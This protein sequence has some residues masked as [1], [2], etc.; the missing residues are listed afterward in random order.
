MLFVAMV[1]TEGVAW[2]FAEH[3]RTT[4]PAID[5]RTV[6]SSREAYDAVERWSLLDL[7]LR[8]R[9]NG[10]LL[11]ALRAVGDRVIANYRREAPAV[12]PEEWRQ[13][14]AAFSWARTLAPRDSSLR[15]KELIAD[16]HVRRLTA[17]KARPA[18][19]ATAIAQTALARFRAAALADPTSPDPYIGMAVTQV[20]SLGDIDGALGSLDEAANRGYTATRRE[21]ALL[22]DA[23]MRRGISGRR[24]AVVLTGEQ[25]RDALDKARSD[26]ER[27]VSSFEP[28]VEFGKAAEHL[29]ACKA[30]VRRVDQQLETDEF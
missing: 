19:N 4:M 8:L 18:S 28:I 10:P 15:S 12:G 11:T 24:R 29:E 9:V 30:Q 21:T 25:R 5:E 3:L 7:G 2:L 23:Y 17:Q 13:A 6:I 26:F 22:G 27:C 1:A 16:G 20:Y 14:Q